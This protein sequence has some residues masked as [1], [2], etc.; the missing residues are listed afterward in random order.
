LSFYESY[1][2]GEGKDTDYEFICSEAVALANLGLHF[3]LNVTAEHYTLPKGMLIES[4][5]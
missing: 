4:G 1:A 2:Q 3:K 5:E